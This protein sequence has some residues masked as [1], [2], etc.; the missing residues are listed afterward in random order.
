MQVGIRQ[1]SKLERRVEATSACGLKL[2]VY[3]AL[4]YYLPVNESLFRAWSQSS[5][6]LHVSPVGKPW[7]GLKTLQMPCLS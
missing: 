2:L 5:S 1:A 3:E 7:Q 4:R 6:D